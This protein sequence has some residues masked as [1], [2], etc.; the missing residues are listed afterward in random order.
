[1]QSDSHD[2]RWYLPGQDVCMQLSATDGSLAVYK[3]AT[4]SAGVNSTRVVVDSPDFGQFRA[5][6]TAPNG[7]S[8]IAFYRN[9][10]QSQPSAGGSTAR[11]W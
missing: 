8:S 10:G 6:P 3:A 5:R 4:F 9:P 7:E 2:L 1:M 11:G